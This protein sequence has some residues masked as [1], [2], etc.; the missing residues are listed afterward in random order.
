MTTKTQHD[1][2]LLD[3]EPDWVV[4]YEHVDGGLKAMNE[5]RYQAFIQEG[6][7]DLAA[8]RV[9]P[10]EEVMRMLRQRVAHKSAA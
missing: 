9:V 8:G 1:H 4:G 3:P 7:D 6:L 2:G 10:H 5:T